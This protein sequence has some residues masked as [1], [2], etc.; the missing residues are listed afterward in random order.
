MDF[1]VEEA[2]KEVTFG[3][4]E[5]GLEEVEQLRK[6]LEAAYAEI[7]VLKEEGHTPGPGRRTT[8]FSLTDEN[9]HRPKLE[10]PPPFDGE[11]KEEW[12]ILNWLAYLENF[13][14]A[15]PSIDE[16]QYSLYA[17]SY[18]GSTAKAW[19]D[20]H[21]GFNAHPVWDLFKED[22]KER[23]LPI[24]HQLRVELKFERTAQTTFLRE[25]LERFQVMVSALSVAG[26]KYSEERLVFQFIKGL[27]KE[28]DRRFILN[29]APITLK[30]TYG[31][32][33]RLL[34]AKTFSN[35]KT[36]AN[37]KGGR[38]ANEAARG[39]QNQGARGK[40]ATCWGCGEE[41]HYLSDCPHLTKKALRALKN[42]RNKRRV[43]QAENLETEE[44]NENSQSQEGEDC[45]Q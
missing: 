43:N 20:A 34:Q 16:S 26:H 21:F 14:R 6:A 39:A 13:L 35:P 11:Y 17:R 27:Q 8:T 38:Q 23:F 2:G 33:T 24:D 29:V 15:Y 32:V 37:P 9:K 12:N 36:R 28:E 19:M 44:G 18:M 22:I 30:D 40:K 4:T 42:Q 10:K 1:P 31:A 25:Y 3:V 7:S 5:G 41:G 45:C